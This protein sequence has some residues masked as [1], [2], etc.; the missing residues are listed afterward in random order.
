M[1]GIKV[2]ALRRRHSADVL[3]FFELS[4]LG[5]MSL[6]QAKENTS[7]KRI[8]RCDVVSF[9]TRTHKTTCRLLKR[10]IVLLLELRGSFR[11]CPCF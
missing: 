5:L 1:S 3:L 7:L 8:K 6:R 4:H 2:V 9:G 10:D 11:F